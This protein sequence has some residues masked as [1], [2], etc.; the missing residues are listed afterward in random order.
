MWCVLTGCFLLTACQSNTENKAAQETAETSN[1]VF[2]RLDVPAFKERLNQTPNPQLI[3]VRTPEEYAQGTIPGAINM[4]FHSPDFEQ[5]LNTL[6]KN[7]PVFVFCQ[8][9]G[10]SFKSAQKMK[11]MGFKEIYELKVGY[12]GWEQ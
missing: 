4:N 3:D 11:E 2:E 1:T 5:N 8:S 7:K 9:G 12:S 6:D 10:R